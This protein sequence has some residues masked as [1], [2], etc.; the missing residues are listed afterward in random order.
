VNPNH[1]TAAVRAR[2]V[3]LPAPLDAHFGVVPLAPSTDAIDLG[4]ARSAHGMAL[5]SIGK[6]DALASTNRHHFFLSRILVRQEAVASSAIEGTYSTLDHLL[7]VEAEDPAVQKQADHDAKQVR[8]YALALERALGDVERNRYDALHVGMIRDL[9]REVMKDNPEYQK[10]YL[11]LSPGQFR[12]LHVIVHIGGGQDIARSIYNPPPSDYVPTCMDEHIAYLRCSGL[13]Q[14]NQSI[15]TRMAIAHAHFEAVH[16]FPDG[17][18]RTGRLLLPL[19]LAAD[20]H[21]PLYIAPHIAA[22]KAEYI[23][24]L[25][26]AQQR[27]DYAPLIEMLS[28]AIITA[29]DRAMDAH[30]ELIG[31]LEDWHRR[32]KWRKNSTQ[33]KSLDFLLGQPVVKI[34]G[35]AAS[36]KVGEEA[37]RTAI[38]QLVSAGI[39]KERTGFKRNRVFAAE[40]V[41]EIYRR[42]V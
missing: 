19:M 1:L 22:F 10:K 36:L 32:Q 11:N 12:P 42:P 17:N 39:L 20:G 38:K 13:Q 31:L 30:R 6:A 29:V 9:Q 27:L 16:P 3:R 15:V 14:L 7:E 33:L 21:T 4:P 8:S 28:N 18:G 41:L 23:N 2:L 5:A 34:K 25:R 24:G 40:E 37:A 35:L 26:A